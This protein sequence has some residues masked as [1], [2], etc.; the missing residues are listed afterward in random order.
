MHMKLRR[1]SNTT[2]YKTLLI[3]W[4]SS[5]VKFIF[6]YKSY[7]YTLYIHLKLEIK[8]TFFRSNIM[9]YLFSLTTAIN[10]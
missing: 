8:F 10:T 5:A 7:M 6:P 4:Y 3:S 9:K 2:S 1:N